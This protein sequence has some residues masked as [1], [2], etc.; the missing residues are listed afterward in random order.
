MKQKIILLLVLLSISLMLNAQ[1]IKEMLIRQIE[2]PNVR[3][4]FLSNPEDGGMVIYT[5]IP[6]L[7]F[8]SNMNSIVKIDEMPLD[9]KYKLYLKAMPNQIIIIKSLGFVECHVHI[10]NLKAQEGRYYILEEVFE[11][12][13]IG[14]GNLSL[15]TDPPG[16]KINIQGVPHGEIQTPY[17]FEDLATNTYRI[18][19]NKDRYQEKEIIVKV[20]RNK[21]IEQNIEL[22]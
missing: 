3:E 19:F 16:A 17:I 2:P 8:D 14:I 9:G 15:I 13:N 22:D 12:S 6:H 20:E 18:T 4:L 10:K 7:T 5:R 11:D 21:N 1:G